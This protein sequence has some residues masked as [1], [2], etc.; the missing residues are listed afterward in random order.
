MYYATFTA[1]LKRSHYPKV[2]RISY[3]T[4]LIKVYP[5]FKYYA[6][7]YLTL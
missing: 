7:F 4:I 5:C 6:L 1:I 2:S 3:F